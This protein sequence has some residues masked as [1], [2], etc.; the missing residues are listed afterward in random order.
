MKATPWNDLHCLIVLVVLASGLGCTSGRMALAQAEK[1]DLV[2]PRL[3]TAIQVLDWLPLNTETVIVTQ[4]PYQL[5]PPEPEGREKEEPTLV[6]TMHYF[7]AWPLMAVRDGSLVKHL[8]GQDIDLAVEGAGQ[9]G[10]DGGG[11]GLQSYRGC[12]ILVFQRDLGPAG[13]ALK[14]ALKQ[15]AKSVEKIGSHE[16][17]SMEEKL[18]QTLW[19]FFFVQPRPNVLLC[20]T[21]KQYLKQVL[22][23]MEK[24]QVERAF[25]ANLPEWKHV[26]TT[27][28]VW[29]IRHSKQGGEDPRGQPVRLAFSFNPVGIGGEAQVVKV[30]YWTD[31][32][33]LEDVLKSW[34]YVGERPWKPTIC[35]I[36]PGVAE[37]TAK[38]P[39]KGDQTRFLFL[40]LFH[41]GHGIG[42]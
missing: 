7:S 39:E 25:P 30:S 9:F 15:T 4:G 27:K 36:A 24:H 12:H 35:M 26:D 6:E 17:L 19:Q 21:N 2:A 38:F 13:N 22:D 20:A 23:R 40:L 29:G 37:V 8:A 16:V 14:K 33:K 5:K 41:L 18:E 28:R 31:D 3:P 11:L 34:T 42:C 32:K 10:K 1:P